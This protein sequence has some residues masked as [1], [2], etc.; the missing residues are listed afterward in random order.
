MPEIEAHCN[1]APGTPILIVCDEKEI[2]RL[3]ELYR[4]GLIPRWATGP[5]I[6]NKLA[7]ARFEI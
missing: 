4:W 5:A 1:I 3:A 6:G 2:G 7:N